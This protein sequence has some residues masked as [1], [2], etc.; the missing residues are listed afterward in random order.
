MLHAR[1]QAPGST[2]GIVGPLP[3]GQTPSPNVIQISYP[4]SH[5]HFLSHHPL[6]VNIILGPEDHP[7]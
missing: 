4:C 3:F 6:D 2:N 5:L 1:I 7:G